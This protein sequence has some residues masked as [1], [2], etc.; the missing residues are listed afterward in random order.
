M[1]GNYSERI[2]TEVTQA[3]EQD[4]IKNASFYIYLLR[5]LNGYFNDLFG[6]FQRIHLFQEIPLL[7]KLS[8]NTLYRN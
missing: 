4:I 2:I 6:R 8:P 7:C 5:R 3:V 1:V